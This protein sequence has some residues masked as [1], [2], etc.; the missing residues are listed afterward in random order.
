MSFRRN[1]GAGVTI[2]QR[3]LLQLV[4]VVGLKIHHRI[5]MKIEVAARGVFHSSPA[6][7]QGLS[8]NSP[9]SH[10]ISIDPDVKDTTRSSRGG[11]EYYVSISDSALIYAKL[12]RT[13]PGT[14]PTRVEDHLAAPTFNFMRSVVDFEAY[15]YDELKEIP[16]SDSHAAPSFRGAHAE[17]KT[18]PIASCATLRGH[19]AQGIPPRSACGSSW[20]RKSCS[21][22]MFW[23]T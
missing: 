16:V 10:Q 22:A 12:P 4:V 15:N 14:P 9:Y 5:L 6:A 13:I 23:L 21:S 20:S 19:A 11:R 1:D 2:A 7:F 3:D 17:S 8:S 18:R